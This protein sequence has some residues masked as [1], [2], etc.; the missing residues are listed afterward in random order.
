MP[1]AP[2]CA[3]REPVFSSFF[4]TEYVSNASMCYDALFLHQPG[5]KIELLS[6]V[7]MYN[8]FE[9]GMVMNARYARLYNTTYVLL[10]C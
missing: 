1:L 3:K 5:L 2:M 9:K 6:D 10:K 8:D 4:S 7:S